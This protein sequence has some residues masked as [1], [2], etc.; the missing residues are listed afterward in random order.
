FL[1]FPK[2]KTPVATPAGPTRFRPALPNRPS[3]IN[4]DSLEGTRVW[5]LLA[6]HF[7]RRPP[8]RLNL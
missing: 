1:A 3:W 8:I 6:H 7:S 4:S 2:P 5:V